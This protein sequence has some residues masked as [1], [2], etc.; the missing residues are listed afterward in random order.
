M[1]LS[2]K[3]QIQDFLTSSGI[4]TKSPWFFVKFNNIAHEIWKSG[5]DADSNTIH[6]TYLNKIISGEYIKVFIERKNGLTQFYL[7]SKGNSDTILVTSDH[8]E[9]I[10]TSE[11]DIIQTAHVAELLKPTT[12]LSK[13]KSSKKTIKE[14]TIE[15]LKLATG[16]K[17]NKL[18]QES[19]IEL[20]KS[21]GVPEIALN[22]ELMKTFILISGPHLLKQLITTFPQLKLNKEIY[23]EIIDSACISSVA[24]SSEIAF[25]Y[26]ER[27]LKPLIKNLTKMVPEKL[28]KFK[29]SKKTGEEKEPKQLK[30]PEPDII[31]QT[32]NLETKKKAKTKSKTKLTRIK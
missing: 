25:E 13:K 29:K 30:A 22:N 16:K 20:F 6:S 9:K 5:C 31:T 19:I 27:I 12:V 15:G 21:L 26:I 3:K 18:I 23:I 1:I 2:E 4:G 11:T 14:T 32:I 10:A 8:I 7:V 17:A 28:S 24:D